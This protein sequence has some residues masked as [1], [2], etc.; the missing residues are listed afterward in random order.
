[1]V[2]PAWLNVPKSA[3]VLSAVAAALVGVGGGWLHL[4]FLITGSP[5]YTFQASTFVGFVVIP[6]VYASWVIALTFRNRGRLTEAGGNPRLAL[7]AVV[8]FASLVGLGLLGLYLS[9]D[10][11]FGGAHYHGHAVG[12]ST[13]LAASALAFA[14]MFGCAWAIAHAVRTSLALVAFA[15]VAGGLYLSEASSNWLSVPAP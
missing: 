3:L 11:E 2:V 6:L 9:D 15:L 13:L 5:D 1:M 14:A 12:G 7:A 8:W 10:A 4:A